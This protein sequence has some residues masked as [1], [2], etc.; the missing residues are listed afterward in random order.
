MQTLSRR[1]KKEECEHLI[2]L[3]FLNL[4]CLLCIVHLWFAK[5]MYTLCFSQCSSYQHPLT[6]QPLGRTCPR[7]RDSRAHA[8]R[9]GMRGGRHVPRSCTTRLS[10]RMALRAA[11]RSSDASRRFWP[12]QNKSPCQTDIHARVPI[13]GR[14][15]DHHVPHECKF[16]CPRG[17]PCDATT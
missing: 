1:D 2:I 16:S 14:R 6:P 17:T 7:S 4:I 12:H 11:L 3:F 5:C 9:P 15:G 8:A 13:L 10:D